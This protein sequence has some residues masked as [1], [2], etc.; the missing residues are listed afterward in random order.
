MPRISVWF[1]RA[2]L[3][4]CLI[5]F[6]VGAWQLATRSGLLMPAPVSLRPV[7]VEVVLVGWLVQLAV[8]VAVW[9]LPFSRGVS[10]DR[11]LWSAWGLLNA[12]IFFVV[13]G[14]FVPGSLLLVIGRLAEV[15]AAVLVVWVLWPRV[16]ALPLRT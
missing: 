6:S 10:H 11:R 4:H 2:A 5:G 1:V 8:G 7:H 13:T 14:A 9:I 12:G 15:G 3:T 16:R